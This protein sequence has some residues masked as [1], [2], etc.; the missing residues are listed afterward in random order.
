MT[1]YT[2]QSVHSSGLVTPSQ[3]SDKTV[4][5]VR[6]HTLSARPVVRLVSVVGGAVRAPPIIAP[7]N[8]GVAASH[9]RAAVER[10]AN[11]RAGDESSRRKPPPIVAAVAPTVLAVASMPTVIG[12]IATTLK[13]VSMTAPALA[14]NDASLLDLSDVAGRSRCLGGEHGCR[15]RGC[16]H[17]DSQSKGDGAAGRGGEPSHVSSLSGMDTELLG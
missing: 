10:T 7:P 3:A 5:R 15:R 8:V 14:T 9:D 11:Y 13:S 16:S 12:S 1:T 4:S 6:R 2:G 17:S